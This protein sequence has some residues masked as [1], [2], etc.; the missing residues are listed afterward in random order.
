[1]CDFDMFQTGRE[2][3]LFHAVQRVISGGPIYVADNA[4]TI[5]F[6]IL[7]ALSASDGFV[8]I[9][10]GY[11]KITTDCLFINPV[12]ERRLFKQVNRYKNTLLLAVFNCRRE[13]ERL[14]ETV[15][16]KSVFGVAEGRYAAY[17]Y[18]DGFMG[19]YAPDEEIAVCLGG[20]DAELISFVKI[21]QGTAVL[22]LQGK[23][24]PSAFAE[25]S[26]TG[27]S[28]SVALRE[29]GTLLI[30]TERVPKDCS[31]PYKISDNLFVCEC[32]Q[33]VLKF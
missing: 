5:N 23:F 14:C 10:D 19:V 8:P 6:D 30:Y 18:H 16:L 17:S 9:C 20:L 3:G 27:A 4:E 26:V 22:G 15:I 11:P 33:V 21:E 7:K 12:A 2:E 32:T 29:K 31:Q 1:M 13:E 28:L 24:M 25:A